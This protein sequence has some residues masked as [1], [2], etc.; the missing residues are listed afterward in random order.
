M[1]IKNNEQLFLCR[2]FVTGQILVLFLFVL[3]TPFELT[4]AASGKKL[5]RP[6][7]TYLKS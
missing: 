1:F 3:S 4:K 7:V 6:S 5:R 2:D